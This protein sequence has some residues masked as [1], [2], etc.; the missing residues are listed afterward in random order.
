MIQLVVR[1]AD[2]DCMQFYSE[3]EE[4]FVT[5]GEYMTR[6]QH[7]HDESLRLLVGLEAR[8]HLTTIQG[9]LIL[10]YEYE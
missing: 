3:R 5:T 9:R 6:G 7:F 10:A 8:T 1:L 4:V 2:V